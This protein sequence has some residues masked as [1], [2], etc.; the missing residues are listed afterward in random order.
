MWVDEN[1]FNFSELIKNVLMKHLNINAGWV[2]DPSDSTFGIL[3]S[4]SWDGNIFGSTVVNF[5]D[6]KSNLNL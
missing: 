2:G 6:E 5:L 4:F 1:N 3:L